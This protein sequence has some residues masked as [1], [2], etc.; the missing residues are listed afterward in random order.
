MKILHVL[1]H[2]IPLQS[3]YTCTRNILREQAVRGWQTCHVTGLKHTADSE[4]EETVD[5]LHFYRTPREP[6]LV[7]KLPVLNQLH[8]VQALRRRVEAVIEQERP[9]LVHAHSPALNGLAALLRRVG[10]VWPV[11][12]ECRASGRTPWWITAP[13]PREGCAIG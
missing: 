1:D 13:V 9:D 4:P 2:S 10:L 7:A 8:G 6:S 12:Y 5:G 11:V 3:G